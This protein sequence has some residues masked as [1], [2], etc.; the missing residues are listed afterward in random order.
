M[1]NSVA[2]SLRT[3]RSPSFEVFFSRL[4]DLTSPLTVRP[5]H[6]FHFPASYLGKTFFSTPHPAR[7]LR[8]GTPI[9]CFPSQFFHR[10]CCSTLPPSSTK[11]FPPLLDPLLLELFVDSLS[12]CTVTHFFIPSHPTFILFCYLFLKLP[13][14]PIS[15]F[16]PHPFPV[17][18]V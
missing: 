1:I 11:S 12:L 17:T 8:E 15:S 9:A 18:S 10:F 16:F 4:S 6:V 13:F 3:P 5:P 2:L 14:F 7:N